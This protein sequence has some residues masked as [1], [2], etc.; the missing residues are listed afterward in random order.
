MLIVDL[1]CYLFVLYLFP[2]D[3][4]NGLMNCGKVLNKVYLNK[5]FLLWDVYQRSRILIIG[6]GKNTGR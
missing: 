6:S 5:H 1:N 3:R 4:S 2:F